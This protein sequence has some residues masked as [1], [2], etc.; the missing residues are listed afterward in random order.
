MSIR[1]FLTKRLTLIYALAALLSAGAQAFPGRTFIARQ[2][3]VSTDASLRDIERREGPFALG[4]QSY[5]L[6]LHEKT[7]ANVSDATISRTLSRVEIVDAAGTISYEKN[8]PYAIEN[9][10][11]Q[12]NIS[13]SAQLMSGATG[14]GIVILYRETT[15][16]SQTSSSHTTDSWQLFGV[17]NGKF[18]LF[19]RPAPIGDGVAGGPY[20]GTIMKAT[21]GQLSVISQPDTIEVRA[22][23]GN[24]YVFVPLRVDWNHGGLAQGQRCM[25]MIGGGL[26]EDGCY[27]RVESV[28]KPPTDEYTFARLFVEANEGMGMPEHVVVQKTSKVEIL[29]S[30]AVTSWVESEELA[31]PVFSDIWL[32]VR[33]DARTGW[34][35]GEEDFASVGLPTGRPAP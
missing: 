31:Q 26:K 16:P 21:N 32:H 12:R 20:M 27:M 11:F 10:R 28:R 14:S 4:G 8:F 18:T 13:A 25:E 6:I 33:I 17:I 15:A 9:S 23:T 30:S 29:G 35:H 1:P 3:S 34:I 2:A 24:F 19:A 5:T 7:L 22:W